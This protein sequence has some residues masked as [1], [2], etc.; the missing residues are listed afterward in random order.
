MLE[1]DFLPVEAVTGPGSKSGDAFCMRFASSEDPEPIVIVIDGGYGPVGDDLAH[2]IRT[3]YGTEKIDLVLSTHPDADHLNGLVRLV[4]SMD[5]R[6]LMLHLPWEHRDDV[7]EYSNIEKVRDLYA[8]AFN[9]NIPVTEPFAGVVRFNG[10]FRVLGPTVSFYEQLLI[11]DLGEEQVRAAMETQN[12]VFASAHGSSALITK[13]VE[14]LDDTDTVSARNNSSVIS[15]VRESDEYHLF[16]GDAGITALDQAADEFERHQ[17]ALSATHIEFFQVPH[18]GSRRNL[19][20][21]VLDRWFPNGGFASTAFI[22]SALAAEKHPGVAVVNELRVRGFELHAT[23]GAH[24][25][26]HHDGKPR[27]AYSTASPL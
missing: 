5:V 15:L 17:G 22:S 27:S 23:E 21:S 7:S 18:H 13:T 14:P 8:S 24:L 25:L 9:K 6:E 12:T 19:G 3:L 26:H 16:T 1:I 10:R 11:E 20:P 4:E 2:H